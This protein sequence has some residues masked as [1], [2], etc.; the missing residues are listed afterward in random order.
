MNLQHAIGHLT[1]AGYKESV[2]TITSE[3]ASPQEDGPIFI[4]KIGKK[5]VILMPLKEKLGG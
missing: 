2:Q 4:F 1:Y 3:I 5:F